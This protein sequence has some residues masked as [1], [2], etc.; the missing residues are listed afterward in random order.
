[1]MPEERPRIAGLLSWY[2]ENPAWLSAAIASMGLLEVDHLVAVDGAY[3]L[4]PD[5]K[6]S[7][8]PEQREAIEET[9]HGM[10]IGLTLHIPP[11]VWSGNEVEKRSAMFALAE[12]VARPDRDWY[13][14]LD[15]DEVV[16]TVPADLRRRLAE[17]NCDVGETTCLNRTPPQTEQEQEFRWDPISR[18]TIPKFF[19]AIPGLRVVGNHYTYALPDGRKLWGHGFDMQRRDSEQFVDFTDLKIEHRTAFRGVFRRE[20]QKDY[21]QRRE[22]LKTEQAPCVNCNA[23]GTKKIE[24]EPELVDNG[25]VE[26]WSVPVCDDC[27]P[28]MKAARDEWLAENGIPA[29]YFE[30][31]PIGS[32]RA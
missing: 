4:Y 24:A 12:M 3:G 9:A 27:Y 5:G 20:Q 19:R 26:A 11:T 30:Q 6:R 18:V 1:M 23:P 17:T 31:G 25:Q 28:E 32:V 14:V 10:G 21:Y 2:D 7:S 22:R 8:S 13:F 16:K 15:A 29:D